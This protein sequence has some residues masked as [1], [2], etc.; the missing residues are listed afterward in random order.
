MQR[1]GGAGGGQRLRA[2]VAAINTDG[3]SDSERG[4]EDNVC[5]VAGLAHRQA[6]D[7]VAQGQAHRQQFKACAAEAVAQGL[8]GQGTGGAQLGFTARIK[9]HAVC[10]QHHGTGLL[11]HIAVDQILGCAHQVRQGHDRNCRASL[12]R[13]TRK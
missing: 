7:A 13:T 10:P 12:A 6:G 8:Q 5:G 9:T 11:K 2:D 3:A 1:E 4:V